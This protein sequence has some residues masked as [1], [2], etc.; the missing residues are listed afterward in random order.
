MNQLLEKAVEAVRQMP[1]DDQDKIARL[2]LSLA[3]GDQSPEQTDPTHLPDILESLAQLRR[4]EF[5]SDADVEIAF[6]RFGS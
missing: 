6:R 4:G 5:A 1:P 2:M 3:E